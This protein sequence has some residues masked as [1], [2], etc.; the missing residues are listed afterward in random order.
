MEGTKALNF[1]FK[2]RMAEISKR[3][4]TCDKQNKEHKWRIRKLAKAAIVT[5]KVE[6]VIWCKD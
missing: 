1:F 2:E 6:S 5:T 4:I 3:N